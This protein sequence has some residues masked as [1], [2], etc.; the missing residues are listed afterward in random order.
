MNEVTLNALINLFAIFSA[1]T[2]S[3]REH[4]RRSF[5]SY[6]ELHLGISSSEEY[7][8]LFD[9]LIDLYGIGEEE[10]PL[11]DMVQQAETICN[12]IKGRL[13]RTEQIMLFLRFLELARSSAVSQKANDLF[14]NV[15]RVFS[16]GAEEYKTY[17]SF[18]YGLTSQEGNHGDF[19]L[20][21]QDENPKEPAIKHIK[22][23]NLDGEIVF[24]ILKDIGHYIFIFRGKENLYLE[25]NPILP[26]RFYAF[27]EGGIIRG[28]RVSPIYFTDVNAAFFDQAETPTFTLNGHNAEFK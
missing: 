26:G 16:I 22:R 15:S 19:L 6:L 7:K 28:A 10:E 1:L 25:G 9:E 24:L 23:E 17:R 21:N 11:F 2:K 3:E 8:K 27:K 18:I 5:S 12:N 13:H 20:I 14:L 4:A